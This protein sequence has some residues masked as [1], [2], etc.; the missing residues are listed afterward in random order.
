MLTGTSANFQL[1]YP[2]AR[3]VHRGRSLLHMRNE[4]TSKP[5]GI[6]ARRHNMPCVNLYSLLN[7][8]M[9]VHQSMRSISRRFPLWQCNSAQ[10]LDP[11]KPLNAHAKPTMRRH[12]RNS[13]APCRKR[14]FPTTV[15]K[16]AAGMPLLATLCVFLRDLI[17]VTAKTPVCRAR[18]K[19]TAA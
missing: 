14:M 19:K 4:V 15:N 2:S 7:K 12:M 8:E 17:S 9:Q 13:V 6:G 16:A 1:N 11:P 10:N 18:E 5:L 3:G